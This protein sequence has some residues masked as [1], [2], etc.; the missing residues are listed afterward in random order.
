MT[1]K[2]SSLKEFREFREKMNE[3]IHASGNLGIRRFFTLDTRA[4]DEGA[5][6]SK[7]KELL[8]LIASMVLRCDDCISY[9][10]I[11]SVIQE[12][13]DDEFWETFNI[14]LVV[15]GSILI[16]H[17]RRAV[18]TLE[19]CRELEINNPEELRMQGGDEGTH[20]H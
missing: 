19:E 1:D 18:V 11:Q 4:Y 10:I 2:T 12:V 17:L 13:T 6:S 20:S 9:H 5:L 8:G 7:V 16:P 14:A 15:S 3:K